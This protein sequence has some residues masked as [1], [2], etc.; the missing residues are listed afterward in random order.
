MTIRDSA[1]TAAMNSTVDKLVDVC[2][3]IDPKIRNYY[4]ILITLVH[5][6]HIRSLS[7]ELGQRLMLYFWY[8]FSGQVPIP[9]V[10]R[11]AHGT[12]LDLYFENFGD[13]AKMHQIAVEALEKE[14]LRPELRDRL[15]TIA[16]EASKNSMS[17]LEAVLS[18][19]PK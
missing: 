14:C 16:R 15:L 11:T 1:D 19:R 10:T 2:A 3:L 7:P 8:G 5:I 18:T 12:L 13:W 9:A 17:A 4:P 6:E